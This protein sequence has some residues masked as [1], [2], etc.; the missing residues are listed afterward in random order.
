M[1]CYL[2]LK[3]DGWSSRTNLLSVIAEFLLVCLRS[4]YNHICCVSKYIKL[5]LL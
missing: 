1:L 5:E 4:L 3:G 2:V